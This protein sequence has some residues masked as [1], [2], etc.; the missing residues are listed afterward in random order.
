MTLSVSPLEAAAPPGTAAAEYAKKCKM[1]KNEAYSGFGW[2]LVA[3]AD[4]G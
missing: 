4:S 3:A 2:L 1:Q